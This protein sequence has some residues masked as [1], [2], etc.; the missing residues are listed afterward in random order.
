MP[1]VLG[2][3]GGLAG[4]V[5]LLSVIVSAS[6]KSRSLAFAE[7]TI[8]LEDAK[9]ELKKT[10]EERDELRQ[11]V[12]ASEKREGAM[13][14]ELESHARSLAQAYEE[15]AGLRAQVESLQN[16]KAQAREALVNEILRATEKRGLTS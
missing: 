7:M 3:L 8:V 6:S 2:A 14:T 10:K 9:N 11:R 4:L 15:I 5:A 13:R 12:G 1:E 16:E